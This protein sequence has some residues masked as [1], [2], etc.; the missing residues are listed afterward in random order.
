MYS[1]STYPIAYNAGNTQPQLT[2]IEEHDQQQALTKTKM[3]VNGPFW[4]RFSFVLYLKTRVLT[5]NKN[6]STLM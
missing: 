6:I 2:E 4:D 5:H 1:T 3:R